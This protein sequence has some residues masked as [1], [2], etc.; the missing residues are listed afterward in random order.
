[1]LFKIIIEGID[2]AEH[3]IIT[4]TLLCMRSIIRLV[5]VNNSKSLENEQGIYPFFRSFC[6]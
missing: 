4:L 2:I 6:L 3:F 5:K 1:M